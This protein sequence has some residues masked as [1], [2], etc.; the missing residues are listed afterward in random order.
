MF[1]CKSCTKLL[2][3]TVASEE[4][5][6]V[7][8]RKPFFWF[9]TAFRRSGYGTVAKCEAKVRDPEEQ[10]RIEVGLPPD[11]QTF[12]EAG[13]TAMKGNEAIQR[14]KRGQDV[15]N[16]LGIKELRSFS[17]LDGNTPVDMTKLK[18]HAKLELQYI[19]EPYALAERSLLLLKNGEVDQALELVRMAG[20]NGMEATVSW[21]H[22]LN[23]LTKAGHLH[24]AW[25]LF[26]EVRCFHRFCVKL[27]D[28]R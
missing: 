5:A 3:K 10:A 23:T 9:A 20:K 28:Y 16:T 15:T 22:I 14:Y 2:I 25:K 4:Y 18:R 8:R 6:Q 26:N 12:K 11:V 7:I 24:T 17:V 1:S 27:K 21:N 13:V 19:E